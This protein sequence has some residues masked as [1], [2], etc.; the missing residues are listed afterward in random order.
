MSVTVTVP[1]ET[2]KQVRA[3][4]PEFYNAFLRAVGN[5]LRKALPV[6]IQNMLGRYSKGR[7]ANSV[8]AWLSTQGV[9]ISIGEGV[10]DERGHAYARYVFYGAPAHVMDQ[11][12]KGRTWPMVWDHTA[13]GGSKGVA[14][15]VHHPGQEARRDILRAIRV[16]IAQVVEEELTVFTLMGGA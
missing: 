8:K 6:L 12:A 4:W 10:T 3:N 7:L 15:R 11:I 1:I 16:L 14:M 13:E 9:R 5:R 2:F